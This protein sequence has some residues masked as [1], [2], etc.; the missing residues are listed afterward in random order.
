MTNTETSARVSATTPANATLRRIRRI[1][2]RCGTSALGECVTDA[3]N[4][5][6]ERRSGGIVL[7]LVA[8]VAHV[9]VD[10]L[11]V[12]VERLVVAQELEQLAAGVDAARPRREVAEDL[13]LRRRQADPTLPALDAPSFEVDDEIAVTDDPSAGCVAE[14]AVRPPQQRLDSA[15][16]LAQA[17]RLREVVVAGGQDENRRL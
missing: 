8:E 1:R 11:L 12:L 14:V 4:R 6:D 15:H 7:D 16:Q 10:R 9:D 17:E 2:R 3:S 5:H 13:E